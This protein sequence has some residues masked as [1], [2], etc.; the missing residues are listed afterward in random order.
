MK[1]KNSYKLPLLL[2][3]MCFITVS[4]AFTNRMTEEVDIL[5]KPHTFDPNGQPRDPSA[6]S[7][8]AYYDSEDTCIYVSLSNAGVSVDVSINNLIT[9]E[10]D[11]YVIPGTGTSALPISGNSGIWTISFTL[12]AGDIYEGSFMI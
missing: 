12:S 5:I 10:T 6:V 11:N 4:T 7:I 1:N 3:M 9:N 2:A 8:S